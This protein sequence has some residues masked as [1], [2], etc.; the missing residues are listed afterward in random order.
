MLKKVLLLLAVTMLMSFSVHAHK[1]PEGAKP[2]KKSSS[3]KSCH[4]A[5][6]REWSESMHSKSSLFSDE[7]HGVM[8]SN[9]ADMMKS[10]GKP[11]DYHCGNCHMPMAGRLDDFIAGKSLPDGKD[12]K[13]RE[14]VGCTFCHRID[15]VIHKGRFNSYSINKDGALAVSNPSGKSKH[16]TR[17]NVIFGISVVCMGCHSHFSNEE[18]VELCVMREEGE[19][20]NCI[21]CHMAKVEGKPALMSMTKKKHRS[22]AIMGGHDPGML[23]KAATFDA[24][25]LDRDGQRVLKIEIRNIIT[26]NFPSTSPMRMAFLKINALDGSGKVVWQNFKKSPMEDR[27]RALF[28]KAFTDGVSIG[29]P[30][31]KATGVAMDT[32]LKNGEKRTLVYTLPDSDIKSITITLI[33]RL[34]PPKAVEEMGIPKN[35]INEK[36]HIVI[37][38]EVTL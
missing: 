23:K 30:P 28:M 19:I 17:K 5:I 10:A 15:S 25:V 9:Y 29:V 18:G 6:Y 4:P 37:K 2:F 35:G 14:G 32:R 11:A 24:A 13:E 38:K 22:H 33:Y 1:I 20:G 34:F 8:H 12:W 26:H 31:W 3:C 21:D 16:K 7:A 27:E 36:N